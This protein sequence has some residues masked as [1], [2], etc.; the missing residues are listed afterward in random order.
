LTD[1]LSLKPQ[2][3]RILH[4]GCKYTEKDQVS[5]NVWS[6]KLFLAGLKGSARNAL[7]MLENQVFIFLC[8]LT[9]PKIEGGQHARVLTPLKNGVGQHGS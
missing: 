7:Y 9:C 3:G 6:G 4:P 1:V 8:V 5:Y 2:N